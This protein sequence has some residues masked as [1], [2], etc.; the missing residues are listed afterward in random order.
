MANH[1]SLPQK[2]VFQIYHKVVDS[3][4]RGLLHKSNCPIHT[5]YLSPAKIQ[6]K[7]NNNK[8]MEPT[9]Y[10]WLTFTLPVITSV[11]SWILGRRQRNNN[12]LQE[13]QNSIDMLV[14]KNSELYQR[15]IEQ[16]GRI[17]ELQ[18]ENYILKQRVEQNNLTI[19]ALKAE[20][21]GWRDQMNH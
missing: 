1:Y 17:V 8:R 2:C 3:R 11:V 13:L 16:N 20:I 6:K 21:Q 12:T 10:K 18:R 15:V 5:T 7:R 4:W 9:I 14:L 19:S